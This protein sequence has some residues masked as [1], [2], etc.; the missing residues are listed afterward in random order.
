MVTTVFLYENVIEKN[1]KVFNNNKNIYS[2][3]KVKRK[4]ALK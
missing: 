4:S 3:Q 1:N 2:G